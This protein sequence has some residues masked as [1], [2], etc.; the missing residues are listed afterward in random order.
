MNIKKKYSN[1]LKEKIIHFFLNN[2][3]NSQA[4]ISKNLNVTIHTVN[5]VLDDYL[6]SKQN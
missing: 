3:N 2:K 1:E 5:S 6:K 4:N